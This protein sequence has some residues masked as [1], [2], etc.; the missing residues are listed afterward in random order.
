M[1]STRLPG[2]SLL[3]LA[4]A[5][6]AGRV[7]ERAQRCQ[8]V[9]EV[10]LTIPTSH[11]DDV[12]AELAASMGIAVER[13]PEADLL[14]RY[15]AAALAHEAATVVRLPGD[16]PVSEPVEIDRTVEGHLAAANEFTS[17]YPE[18]LDN[19]YPSGLGAEV[20]SFAALEKAWR[21]SGDLR[22]REHPH[23]HF[24]NRPTAYRIGTI[25]CPPGIRRPKLSL[26]VDNLDDYQF[27]AELYDALQPVD[28]NFGPEQILRWYDDVYRPTHP[29]APKRP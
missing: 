26:D 8:R 11:D 7:I 4:G 19:G 16:N 23:Q 6:L 22:E 24:Y 25:R 27:M 3:P 20:I 18:H 9:D 12:L 13:G 21:V 17:S 5:P 15:H 2:K 1:G 29:P 10:V 28:A 14:E